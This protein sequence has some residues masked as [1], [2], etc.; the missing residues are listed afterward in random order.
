MAR[1]AGH[2]AV[3]RFVAETTPGTTPTNPALKL[4]SRGTAKVKWFKDK[5]LK[6][7]VDIGDDTVEGY[8]SARDIYGIEV[9]Y[10][11]H[12]ASDRLKPFCDRDSLGLPTA[13]TLEYQPDLNHTTPHYI[14]GKGW[15]AQKVKLVGK[16]GE[17]WVVSVVFTGGS[18]VDPATTGV[19]I[20][21]GS[22]EAKSAIATSTVVH[23]ASGA[24]TLDGA[25]WAI[26][27]DD[28]EV[29]FDHGTEAR[30][31]TG[32]VDPVAAAVTAKKL[33]YS[34][35][36]GIS[37]DEGASEHYANVEETSEATIVIP[38]GGTGADKLTL[39]GVR[40]PR[41]E[42]ES[43]ADTDLFYGSEPFVATGHAFGTV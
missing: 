30:Y 19:V 1:T 13:F 32:S 43:T 15:R 34:G 35:K 16:V 42:G 21:T 41:I 20:G 29:E 5:D 38:F 26:I 17:A 40:F 31:T 28:F 36:A 8:Y 18:L 14:V 27:L 4:F 10:Q 2:N 23:F 22:R 11:L 6:E 37:L 24:I 39:T 12:D 9:E 3:I 33:R 7:Q 25:A